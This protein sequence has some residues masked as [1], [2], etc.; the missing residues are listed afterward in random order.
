MPETGGRKYLTAQNL[1]MMDGGNAGLVI[2]HAIRSITR[3][4]QD[5]PMDKTA[6][7]VVITLSLKPKLHDSRPELEFLE[8]D[9]EVDAK[10][11]KRKNPESYRMLPARDGEMPLFQP[12]APF[13]PRQDAFGYREPDGTLYV[14]QETGEELDEPPAGR[15][16][17]NS[18]TS[19]QTPADD[20]NDPT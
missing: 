7:K 5:R 9:I 10:T 12:T 11:P 16:S 19:E 13:D 4:V 6:R 14:D 2:D 20:D 15:D 1:H 3:D 17:G 8:T 18:T